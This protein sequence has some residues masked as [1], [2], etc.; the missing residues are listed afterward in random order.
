MLSALNDGVPKS[1]GTDGFSQRRNV[2]DTLSN[3]SV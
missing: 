3:L 2:T 1:E